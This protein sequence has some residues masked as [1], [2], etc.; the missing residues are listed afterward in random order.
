M[1]EEKYKWTVKQGE[2]VE[3]KSK[4]SKMIRTKKTNGRNLRKMQRK[5][6]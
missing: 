1:K 4:D 3:D 5:E 6:T 2:D